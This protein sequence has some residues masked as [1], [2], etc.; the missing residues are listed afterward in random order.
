MRKLTE[1]QVLDIRARY[2]AGGTTQG[3]LG[4][5]FGV[6]QTTIQLITSGKHWAHL[7]G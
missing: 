3:E 2:A 7:K 1:E 4:R 5:Q 6:H